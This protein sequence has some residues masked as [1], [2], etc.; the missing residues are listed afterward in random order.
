MRIKAHTFR[1]KR[2][3]IVRR[4]LKKERCDGLCDDPTEPGKMITLDS[5]L[6]GQRA[7]EVA[8]HESLH[9]SAWDLS[10]EAVDAISTDCA[11]F[12]W[13]LG[14]KLKADHRAS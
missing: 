13:R 4:K 10:E 14:Y 3:K 12:L 6:T 1:G 7:L 8:L 2:Y 11:A 9:A 5:R